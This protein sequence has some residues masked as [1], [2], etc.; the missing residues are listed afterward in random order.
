MKKLAIVVAA[1]LLLGV[2]AAS[3]LHA[4]EEAKSCGLCPLSG[5]PAQKEVAV[6][7]KGKQVYFCCPGCPA[8]FEK[9]PEKFAKKVALQ[10]LVTDQIVQ[11]AC[12][13]SGGPVDAEKTV[14]LAD[15]AEVAF[16]CGNCQGK[17]AKAAPEDALAMIF[18]TLEKGFTLQTTCPLSGK[19]INPEV[20]VSYQDKDVYF[21]CPGC[22]AGFEADPAKYTA[23]LPQFA[24]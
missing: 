4:E 10:W 17:V 24:K 22:P 15:G 9:D 16:C 5:K 19:P 13:L 1:T 14:K 6:E 7:Y 21:C 3:V 11:V 8:G 20:S 18:G 23:K 2:S 12:P